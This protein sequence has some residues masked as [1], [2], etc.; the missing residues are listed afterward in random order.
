M[1]TCPICHKKIEHEESDPAR[2][3]YYIQCKACGNFSIHHLAVMEL[4]QGHSLGYILSALARRAT[5]LGQ[6]FEIMPDK[7]EAYLSESQA[8][9]A[10]LEKID[11]ILLHIL[12]HSERAGEWIIVNVEN[13][14]PIAFAKDPKEFDYMLHV[15]SALLSYLEYGGND[16]EKRKYRFSLPGWSRVDEIR[17]K[18]P[19]TGNQCFVAMCFDKQMDEAYSNG[20][21]RGI[22]AAGYNPVRIDK[23]EHNNEITDQIIAEIRKSR[24]VV[25]DFTGQR[26]GVYFEAG[27]A[28]GLGIPVIWTCQEDD[29]KNCHFDTRQYNHIV[30]KKPED[31]WQ[32]LRD[33]ILATV[34]LNPVL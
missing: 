27:F 18:D 24:L 33:R 9:G 21:Y 14:Y 29:I 4:G 5:E 15:A 1:S 3:M 10:F 34:P 17:R 20:F 6:L 13:D 8:P 30:W 12:R 32:K 19:K 28:C 2:Q 7:L 31:L 16:N 22:K 26:G 25:A 23:V 11:L